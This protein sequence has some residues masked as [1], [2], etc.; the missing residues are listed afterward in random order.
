MLTA[1]SKSAVSGVRVTHSFGT[2]RRRDDTE[3]SL[4]ER[5]RGSVRL[6]KAHLSGYYECCTNKQITY[7]VPV[8]PRNVAE[9][10][11]PI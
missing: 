10:S 8:G 9:Q 4:S 1:R 11:N 6:L 7:K 5:K 2:E 3:R